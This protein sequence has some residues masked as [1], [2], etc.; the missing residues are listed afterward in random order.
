MSSKLKV[1]LDYLDYTSNYNLGDIKSIIRIFE[2]LIKE[3]IKNNPDLSIEKVEDFI[4]N[5]MND[6]LFKLKEPT[7]S[8]LY[9]FKTIK[10]LTNHPHLISD[11]IYKMDTSFLKQES[12]EYFTYIS[13][14]E[15]N[16]KTCIQDCLNAMN[17]KFS[18]EERQK[19]INKDFSPNDMILLQNKIKKF[20][21]FFYEKKFNP[22][23][24]N[25]YIKRIVNYT[26][27]LD[28]IGVLRQNSKTHNKYLKHANLGFLGFHYNNNP[29]EEIKKPCICDLMDPQFVNNF[30]LDELTAL[31][32][33]YSNRVAK[34]LKAYNNS[35]YILYKTGIIKK[36]F[37]DE[38]YTFDL[39]DEEITNLI[40]QY[41]LLSVPAKNFIDYQSN[42]LKDQEY[43]ITENTV[44]EEQDNHFIKKAI[45][46]Y[47]DDYTP[48]FSKL[49]PNYEHDL[50]KDLNKIIILESGTYSAY[51]SKDQSLE[52]LLFMLIE[53]DKEI[54]WGIVLNDYKNGSPS[55][56]KNNDLL[57]CF[58][59]KGFNMPIPLHCSKNQV[60]TFLKN[61]TGKPYIRVYKGNEDMF[62]DNKHISTQICMK[63]S[64]DQRKMLRQKA[65][66]INE[67]QSMYYK[68]VKHLQWMSHP[69]RPPE[70]IDS[71]N[72]IYDLNTGFLYDEI[73]LENE[74]K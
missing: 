65:E 59:M 4:N 57:L 33:S 70:F 74:Q 10:N 62:V 46:Y 53:K 13:D 23:I 27:I 39:S 61:Y 31:S 1:K 73:D 64:K 68:F 20:L 34:G 51:K 25:G 12:P 32:A 17:E 41:K 6:S 47:G 16:Y 7:K 11:T 14:I 71:Q 30:S 2:N 42:N 36:Y 48:E 15:K 43:E 29:K 21:E 54:N 66:T 38:N 8:D 49:L 56:N 22:M 67:R 9:L 69:K 63:L 26:Q 35:L 40:K 44:K 72:L 50:L 5:V 18:E 24:R 28:F 19:I 3:S 60:K 45:S 52:A 58:D 55:Q 37:E